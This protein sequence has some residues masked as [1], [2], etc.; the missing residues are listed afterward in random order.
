[1]ARLMKSVIPETWTS[2]LALKS[3][4]ASQNMSLHMYLKLEICFSSHILKLLIPIQR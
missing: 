4:N 3:E 2:L 1:M